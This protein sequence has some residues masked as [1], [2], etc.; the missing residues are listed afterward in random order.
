MNLIQKYNIPTPKEKRVKI[1]EILSFDTFPCVLKID[2]P[3]HKSDIGGVITDIQNN[4]E[5][6][7]AKEIILNNLKKHDI[8]FDENSEFLIQEEV[9]GIELI[10]GGKFDGIFGEVLI[11]GSGGT[12]VEIE[13]DITY[14]DTNADENEI[15]KA[16]KKTKISKIF[17]EFRGKK[18]NL[19]A[20]IDVI[21]KLQIMFNNENIT[22]FDINPLIVNEKGAIAVDVRIKE[23]KKNKKTFYSKKHS[24]FKNENIAIFGATDKEEKVGYAIAKNALNSKANIYFVNP[25]LNTLFDKRVYKSIDELPPIDTSVIAIPT[26]F[27]LDTVEKMACKGCKNFIIISAGFK[28]IGNIEAEKKLKELAIKYDLNIVGPNCLGIYNAD[29][30][31]NLTFA[32][33]SIY[34][35]DIGLISQSGAVL[36]AIMDKAA[37]NKIGFSHIISMGNMADFNFANAINELNNQKNCKTISIYAE[38][39]QYGKEFLKA[40]RNSKKDILI[41]K[42]GKSKAAKKAAFSHTGNLAGDFEMFKILSENAG[43]VFKNSIESLIYSP[44]YKAKE[45]IIVTNAG[46]P[47]TILTDLVSQ[48]AKIKELDKKTIEKLNKVLPPTWSHNNPI[49]VIG[50]A[51]DE[52]YKAAL[53]TVK[54]L[55][56]I[57]FVIITPQYMTDA[58]S[59]VKILNN[60]KYIPILLGK[61]S[62]LDTINYLENQNRLYFTSLEE[63]AKIL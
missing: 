12:L 17:P 54:N 61:E 2:L 22:E 58:L 25:H 3:V 52:R 41:F 24:I 14:I 53:E 26:K 50:D 7:K 19:G 60:D 33:S 28:E 56:D 10:I 63:A 32:K 13:K 45:V 6:K 30:E 1:N 35:G 16:I 21:K 46:G 49:D 4:D 5:L 34:K 42:A 9:K 40:I 37:Q 29:K 39:I 18:Y 47:G 55:G 27:V 57:I 20:V 15:T 43:A 44:E 31:L 23:G 51:T 8:S 48:Y 38:G 59:I 36:T 11:F 62:F